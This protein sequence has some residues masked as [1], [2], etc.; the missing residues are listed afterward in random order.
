MK[1]DLTCAVARDLLPAYM[2]RLTAPETNEAVERHLA[3]CPA[4]AGL[5]RDLAAPE[6]AAEDAA[7]EVDYLKTVKRRTWR[8]VALAVACTVLVLLAGTAAKL[9]F[10]G[11]PAGIEGMAW[12]IRYGGDGESLTVSVSAVGSAV[13][14]KN[15][16]IRQEG[17]AVYIT[18]REVLVSPFYSSGS[19]D[20]YVPPVEGGEV[21]SVYLA[22]E[23]IW[24]ENLPVSARAR[25]LYGLRT[26]YVGDPAALGKIAS[27]LN[28]Q[29]MLGTYTNSLQTS[30]RPYGWTLEFDRWVD[31][32]TD[33][34]MQYLAPQML[35]LVGNLEEVSW[36]Y[37]DEN[38]ALQSRTVTLE[39][40]DARLA[41][42]TE[43]YNAANG[44]HW[45][46]MESVKDY[47]ASPAALQQ[48]DVICWQLS[49]E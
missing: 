35:A 12:N 18:A 46:A 7:R 3:E 9:F 47:A 39:E 37:P 38:G 36:T 15:W 24:Q 5:L 2:E 40:A 22:G 10:I 30:G 29:A 48:L 49:R 45:T 33:G 32:L 1:N 43:A 6:A 14:Y 42:L 4:C 17:D 25:E 20:A 16:N 21:K 44:T 26:P 31:D 19:Y 8:R 23:L 34:I 11:E 13:A 28:L 27:A 41:E